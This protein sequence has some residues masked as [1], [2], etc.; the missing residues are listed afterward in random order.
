MTS[1][2]GPERPVGAE[3]EAE[4]APKPVL[5]PEEARNWRLAKLFDLRSFIGALLLIF[6]VLV[7]IPGIAA[8][9]AT[10]SKSAG[11]NL[12]LWIG[13]LMLVVGAFFVTWILLRPPPPVTA[14]EMEA[15]RKAREEFG[16]QG[17]PP[18]H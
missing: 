11:I 18:A 17:G 10:I 7:I 4:R 16:T 6:G 14:A 2:G 9:Q 13:A 15:V 3:M 5:T 1:A 12:S 8:S